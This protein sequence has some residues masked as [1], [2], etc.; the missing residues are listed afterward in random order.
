[1]KKTLALVALYALPLMAGAQAFGRD[2]GLTG[3]LRSIVN[4]VND[5]I[6]PLIIAAAILSFIWGM[7]KFFIMG[8]ADEEKR[9]SGKQLMIWAVV[10]LV[11]MLSIQ[12]IVN[13]FA[14][15]VGLKNQTITTP[16]VPGF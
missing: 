11:L 12:G 13:I 15:A 1:M 2:G 3:Y 4:F 16:K 7:F 9:A 5:Y 6:I 8:G 14:D 10:G